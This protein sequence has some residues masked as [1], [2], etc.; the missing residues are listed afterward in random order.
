MAAASVTAIA[1]TP[2]SPTP[3]RFAGTVAAARDMPRLYS[4]LVSWRGTLVLEQYFNGARAA[5]PA[6]VKSVSKSVISALV[7]IAIDRGL[8]KSVREP[9]AQYFPGALDGA[10]QEPKR[11]I[12]IEDLLTMRSGLE[13]TS[14]RNYGAW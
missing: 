12:T 13:S 1:Q 3:D 14:G 5:R 6:N 8:I 7:G 9:I 2:S 11:R 4:L 10:A